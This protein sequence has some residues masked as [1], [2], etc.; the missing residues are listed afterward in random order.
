MDVS[1]LC[2]AEGTKFIQISMP[3]H[4]FNFFSHHVRSLEC[5][6]P[7]SNSTCH[8][9]TLCV[10]TFYSQKFNCWLN[11]KRKLPNSWFHLFIFLPIP[12]VC[13]VIW[14][15]SNHD[16]WQEVTALNHADWSSLMVISY[17]LLLTR[18]MTQNSIAGMA[19]CNWSFS[20]CV[21]DV[22]SKVPLVSLQVLCLKPRSLSNILELS[23]NESRI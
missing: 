17:N 19:F 22:L 8:I 13:I 15:K 6:L 2:A 16:S 21:F 7:A 4:K 23:L 5:M 12:S 1:G 20:Q 10:L 3:Q 14:S 11:W 9:I 18:F